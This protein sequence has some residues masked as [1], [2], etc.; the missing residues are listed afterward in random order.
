MIDTVKDNDKV[1]KVHLQKKKKKQ[2]TT[3]RILRIR[4]K[5]KIQN[6]YV[7]KRSK[8]YISVCNDRLYKIIGE[9]SRKLVKKL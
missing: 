2:T 3:K 9:R 6:N 1:Q 8:E 7:R 5:I 4:S